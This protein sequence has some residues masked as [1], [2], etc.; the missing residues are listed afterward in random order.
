[1]ADLNAAQRLR[2]RQAGTRA[3]FAD[4]ERIR[5]RGNDPTT[6]L[7][8][9]VSGGA[10]VR[11]GGQEVQAIVATNGLLK[12]GQVVPVTREGGGLAVHG[13]PKMR[14]TVAPKPKPETYRKVQIT[15][16][17]FGEQNQWKI[18]GYKPKPQ[19]A[20]LLPGGDFN[21]ETAIGNLAGT[22]NLG[23]GAWVLTCYR[24]NAADR[25]LEVASR[26]SEG[27]SVS[28]IITLPTPTLPGVAG[29]PPT[30]A[31]QFTGAGG[32]LR[33]LSFGATWPGGC[34]IID[35]KI[36]G[37]AEASNNYTET[38]VYSHYGIDN[39][40]VETGQ[41]LLSFNRELN[42]RSG[43]IILGPGIRRSHSLTEQTV[44][45]GD[46]TG[47]LRNGRL[48][49][50]IACDGPTA[51]YQIATYSNSFAAPPTL[52]HAIATADTDTPIPTIDPSWADFPCQLVDD[53]LYQVRP[54]IPKPLGLDGWLDFYEGES[55]TIRVFD[56]AGG[57][58]NEFEEPFYKIPLVQIGDSGV[59]NS[60]LF[61]QSI[62]RYHPR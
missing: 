60:S 41:E 38:F 35:H 46:Q 12:P 18:A 28:A 19:L 50:P 15:Y 11:Q 31:R 22:H 27:R 8:R 32:T 45:Q 5:A 23:K 53:R 36:A 26:N 56:L 43:E 62:A 14:Q 52:S 4:R 3:E 49:S 13:M 44:T 61:D 34:V 9:Y 10:I 51:V 39:G 7:D 40:A 54:K 37:Y 1:M 29:L 17:D 24:G 47:R 33:G 58:Y 25:Q 48:I 16:T 20:K 30:F 2:Q 59:F 57:T 55:V 42:T 6:V 21:A